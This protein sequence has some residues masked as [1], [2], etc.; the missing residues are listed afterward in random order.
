VSLANTQEP[1]F[2]F[3]R[4]ASRPSHEGAAA[5]L[6]RA[7]ALCRQAGFRRI[8]LRGDTDF[9]QSAHLDRWHRDG[10]G[11][12]FGIDAQPN[13]VARAQGLPERVWAALERPA[14][15]EVATAPRQRPADVKGEVVRRRGYRNLRLVSEQVAEFNYRRGRANGTTCRR[16]AQAAGLGTARGSHRHGDALPVSTH[17]PVDMVVRGGGGVR[18]RP[19][20]PG[21]PDRA[22]QER[23][24]GL[25]G[26]FEHAGGELGLHGD[27]S[28]GLEPEGVAGVGA[29]RAGSG[30][31][32]LLTMEFKEVPERGDVAA[33]PDRAGGAAVDCTRL[34]R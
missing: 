25:A 2:L 19:L 10:I 28:A 22:A 6:D 20:Q 34:L 13:L 8:L 30:A 7:V 3:N 4:P 9:T 12:V 1:L 18:Q 21:E 23:G 15:Y 29:S 14:R 17:R 31:R 33:V 24:A 26:A 5:Y 11:F 27:R 32:N 16:A